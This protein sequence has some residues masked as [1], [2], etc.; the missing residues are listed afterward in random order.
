MQDKESSA[1][2][3]LMSGVAIMTLSTAIVKIIGLVYKIPMLNLLSEEGMAYFNAAYNIYVMFYMISTAGL[4]VAIS[5][6]VSENRVHG[7]AK[8]I[9]KIYRVALALFFVIG[10]A[11][12]LCMLLLSGQFASMIE[13]DMSVYCIIAIAPTLFFVCLSSAVRGYFQG[14][15]IMVHTGVSQIIEAV[16]KMV[17]GLLFAAWALKQGYDLPVVAAFGVLGLTIGVVLSALYLVLAKIVFEA[18][19]KST[20]EL[21]TPYTDTAKKIFSRLV[22]I[23][24]PITLSSSVMGVTRIVDTALIAS[25]LQDIGFSVELSTKIYGAYSTLAV[26]VY[27]LPPAI[28][29]GISLSLVPMLTAAIEAKNREKE[30]MVLS[31]SLRVCALFAMPCAVGISMFSRPILEL[32]F[33][34]QTWAVDTAAPLLSVLGIAVLFASMMTVTNAILQA[35]GQE[36]KPIISMAVGCT[37]NIVFN[38]LLIG[39]E[40]FNIYGA[41]LSTLLCT[42]TVM[43][44]NCFFIKKYAVEFD[45]VIKLLYRPMAAAI[46]SVGTAFGV[47]MLLRI[48][49]GISNVFSL[50]G[51]AVAALLYVVLAL[52]FRAVET[53]DIRILPKGEKVLNFFRKIKLV[54]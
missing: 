32:L 27:N 44:L 20:N 36:R 54:K 38:Y 49:L 39:S 18:K 14:H 28:I 22:K 15:Q 31:S 12:M 16:A 13:M 45:G 46:L 43:I 6:L 40:T 25:R 11:G 41:P 26:P 48:K 30:K 9:K 50:V 7:N 4:P 8:N 52:V 35:Y 10:L 37:V 34:G 29:S 5:I 53:E 3:Q 42:A 1:R 17:I 51:I 24:V 19:H 47:Y 2:R 23:S 33:A 21:Q